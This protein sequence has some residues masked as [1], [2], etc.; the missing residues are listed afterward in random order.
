MPYEFI[1]SSLCVNAS[2]CIEVAKDST[3]KFVLLRQSD[4]PDMVLRVEREEW[5]VFVE[6]VKK[7]D[8]D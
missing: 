3:A 4:N 5:Q 6:G 8:F 1:R 7:G 2:S